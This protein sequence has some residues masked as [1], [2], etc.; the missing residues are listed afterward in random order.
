MIPSMS[1]LIPE[2]CDYLV[3]HFRDD[4]YAGN[5]ALMARWTRIVAN[6]MRCES[7]GLCKPTSVQLSFRSLPSVTSDRNFWWRDR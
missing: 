4:N 1:E 2:D 7:V 6:I 3:N 5:C